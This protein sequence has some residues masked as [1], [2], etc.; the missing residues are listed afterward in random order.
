M[1]MSRRTDRRLGRLGSSLDDKIVLPAHGAWDQARRAWQLTVDHQPSAVVY[2]ESAQDVV[3]AV[4]FA[5]GGQRVLGA[6]SDAV[7]GGPRLEGRD[8]MSAGRVV[9]K[10]ASRP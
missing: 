6:V 3:A 2:P 4:L 10:P 1:A 5:L 8:A 7:R 9:S